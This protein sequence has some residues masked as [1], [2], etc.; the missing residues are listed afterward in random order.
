MKF[1]GK[2][3]QYCWWACRYWTAWIHKNG[4]VDLTSLARVR[5]NH[6]VMYDYQQGKLFKV[7]KKY[8]RK[9]TCIQAIK[10]SSKLYRYNQTKEN[11]YY[12][13]NSWRKTEEEH[14]K[15]SRQGEITRKL[16][17]MSVRSSLKEFIRMLGKYTEMSNRP[18]N[19]YAVEDI[20]GLMWIYSKERPSNVILPSDIISNQKQFTMAFCE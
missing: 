12:G 20:L 11:Y 5:R 15:V 14:Q 2:L 3:N 1:R 16:K 19:I 6:E 9:E 10:N 7:T 13:Y 18:N 4:I 8:K 17:N